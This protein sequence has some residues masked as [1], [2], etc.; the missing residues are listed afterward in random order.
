MVFAEPLRGDVNIH[1]YS[2]L[3]VEVAPK[4]TISVTINRK[5]I[6]ARR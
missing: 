3:Q 4:T 2:P 6:D 1:H 5:M